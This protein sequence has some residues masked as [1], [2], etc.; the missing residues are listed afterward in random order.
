MSK[1]VVSVQ[2]KHIVSELRS[3]FMHV[4]MHM[5]RNG[6]YVIRLHHVLGPLCCSE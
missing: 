6:H 2:T 1:E 4:D 5:I 3:R